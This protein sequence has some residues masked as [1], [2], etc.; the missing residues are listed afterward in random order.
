[1]HS[2][3][4]DND[5]RPYVYG[6]LGVIAFFVTGAAASVV[7]FAANF[8]PVFAGI[9]VAWSVFFG[10]GFNLLD[11]VLWKTRLMQIFGIVRVPDLNGEWEG[12]LKTSYDETKPGNPQIPAEALHPDDDPR[13]EFRTIEAKLYIDQRYRKINIRQETQQS[14]SDSNGATI[15]TDEGRWPSI[16]YQYDND[17]EGDANNSLGPHHG[18]ADLEYQEG[19]SGFDKL[20]GFYY[21]GPNRDNYGK[22]TL[23]APDK[24]QLGFNR[25]PLKHLFHE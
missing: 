19:D 7:T 2:Y 17:P 21:T 1:M 11:R 10:V 20:G 18:T 9:G 4:T 12:Y 15:L 16:S 23:S 25:L 24:I 6:G 8:F 3:S 5:N 14:S 13:D 22:C